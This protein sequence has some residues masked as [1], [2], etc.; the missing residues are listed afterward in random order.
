MENLV[1]LSELETCDQFRFP[2]GSPGW[3]MH[4]NDICKVL[5]NAYHMEEDREVV[6]YKSHNSSLEFC[7]YLENEV[8]YEGF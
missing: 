8:I 5:G 3:Q 2:T 1:K 4:G 7:A 6:R